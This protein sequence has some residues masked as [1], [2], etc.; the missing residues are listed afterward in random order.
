MPGGTIKS[1]SQEITVRTVGEFNSIEQIKNTPIM[2]PTGGVVLLKDLGNVTDGYADLSSLTYLNGEPGMGI[3]IQKASDANTVVVARNINS[4]LDDI[5][6]QFPDV[7]MTKVVDSS[8]F[9]NLAIS[10][11]G[12]SAIIGAI[13]AVLILYLFLRNLRTTLIIAISIPVSIVAVFVM[14][15]FSGMTLNLISLGGLALG[16]G[17][18]VDNSIVVLENVFRYR[19]EGHDRFESASTGAKE[20]GMAITGS[21]LTTIAVFLPIVFIQGIASQ[22]FGELAFTVA[23]SLAASLVVAIT[24]VPMLSYQMMSVE[25]HEPKVKGILYR[26]SHWVGSVLTD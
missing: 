9:I 12:S 25:T 2:L 16:V 3:V 23:F 26:L 11:V 18:L 7:K 5:E 13:L 24:V 22:I 8:E 19:Q 4:A 14:M 21:T 1:S 6:K 10:N 20:V 17:M 15:Y